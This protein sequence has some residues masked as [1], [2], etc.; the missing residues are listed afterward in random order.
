MCPPEGLLSEPTRAL[1]GEPRVPGR[2]SRASHRSPSGREM[3]PRE[4]LRDEPLEP[5]RERHVSPGGAPGRATG[6]LPG[7]KRVPG[8]G[9]WA[10]HWSPSGRDTC[11]RKGLLGEP[12]EPFRERHVSPTGGSCVKQPVEALLLAVLVL[13]H[14]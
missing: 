9:S 7:E 11:P 6:A 13:N 3:C 14:R 5:I 2:G 10:S 4:G 1:P 12:P 8:R